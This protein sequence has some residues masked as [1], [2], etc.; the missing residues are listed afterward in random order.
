[1]VSR[2][3]GKLEASRHFSSGVLCAMTGAAIG[4]AAN[5]NAADLSNRRRFIQVS[6]GRAV[7]TEIHYPAQGSRSD[8]RKPTF[9]PA[10]ARAHFSA[11]FD[12]S[13]IDGVVRGTESRRTYDGSAKP[14]HAGT[15][16]K[17]RP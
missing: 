12:P 5:P 13:A 11:L 8:S 7:S 15:L 10:C 4:V 17:S 14:N 3:F 6:L 1:M 9:W 16:R 2:L